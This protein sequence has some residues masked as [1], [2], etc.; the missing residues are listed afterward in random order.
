MPKELIATEAEVTY[1]CSEIRGLT[2]CTSSSLAK[3]LL[4]FTGTQ[5]VV[6]V[7][8]YPAC[9][10][11]PQSDMPHR[12]SF[13]RCLL[14]ITHWIGLNHPF[15]SAS[16]SLIAGTKC[17]ESCPIHYRNGFGHIFGNGAPITAETFHQLRCLKPLNPPNTKASVFLT[18]VGVA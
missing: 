8:F 4:S 13:L 2:F 11:S 17:S 18:H 12:A 5:A 16:T 9:D 7:H 10:N 14:D 3:P 1:F 15:A 6:D